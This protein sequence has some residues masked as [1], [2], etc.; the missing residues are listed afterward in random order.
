MKTEIIEK[1]NK[2]SPYDQGIF[3]EPN[4]IPTHIKEH[5]IYCRYHTGGYSGGTCWDDTT[6][7]YSAEEPEKD[8]FKI[9]DIVLEELFPDIKY[10]QYKQ[11]DALIH[12][13]TETEWGYYGN[14]TD[15]KCE[16]IILSELE[17]LIGKWKSE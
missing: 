16:Y 6:P 4:M 15:W 9:L 17:A 5:V 14:S 8:R 1:L 13:N 3:K 11:I 12:D 7:S 10:L 2:I